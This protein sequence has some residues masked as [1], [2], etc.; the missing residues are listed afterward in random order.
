MP[1]GIDDHVRDGTTF[2]GPSYKAFDW[3]YHVADNAIANLGRVW[4]SGEFDNWQDYEPRI[5]QTTLNS[6]NSG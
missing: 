1:S 5:Y 6:P 4:L 3:F 2:S